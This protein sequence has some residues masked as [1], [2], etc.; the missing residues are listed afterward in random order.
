MDIN[1]KIVIGIAVSTF[2]LG[3]VYYNRDAARKLFS[4]SA[5]PMLPIREDSR[6]ASLVY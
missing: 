6:P 1:Y 4:K 5:A 3:L 2:I